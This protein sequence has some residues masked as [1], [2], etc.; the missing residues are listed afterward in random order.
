M[1]PNF[2]AWDKFDKEMLDVHGINY[3]ADGVWTKEVFD[4]EDNGDFIYFSDIELLQS[5]GLFDKNEK[6]IFEGILLQLCQKVLK[7]LAL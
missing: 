5:T 2:K 4:E 7:E 6:E 1:I 3:D